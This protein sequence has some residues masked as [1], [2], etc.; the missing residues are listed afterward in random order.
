MHVSLFKKIIKISGAVL[1]S[2]L[3]ER[4]PQ[5]PYL[6]YEADNARQEAG[7]QTTKHKICKHIEIP[8]VLQI[9]YWQNL[10]K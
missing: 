9:F 6:C 3:P 10:L 7:N 2:I 8:F 4:C 5:S 1:K